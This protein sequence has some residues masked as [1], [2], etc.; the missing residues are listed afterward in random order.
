M[1]QPA[2]LYFA[3]GPGRNADVPAAIDR[4]VLDWRSGADPQ[5][6]GVLR[7]WGGPEQRAHISPMVWWAVAGLLAAL[8]AL[9]LQRQV[10]ERTRHLL[11]SE[12]KLA[13]ILDSVGAF[14]YI[15]GRDYRYQYANLHLRELFGRAANE[16]VG[17]DDAAFFESATATQIRA[18][19]RRVLELG[20]RIEV[21]ELNTHLADGAT[22]AY[23]S[24]KI[25]LRL[26]DGTIHALCGISTDITER[27]K[28]EESLRLAAS[29]FESFEGM[30][31]TGPDQRILKA[32]RSYARLTG[33][34]VDELL[35]QTPALLRSG[36]ATMRSSTK[37]CATA[38]APP[39]PGRAKCGTGARTARCTRLG[40][41]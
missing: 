15:K 33:Y 8:W 9:V 14:I 40:S 19:D 7:R 13:T 12:Q 22:R 31:V 24:V 17:Q 39:G 26:P 36:R 10:R 38:C 21:E 11:V 16:V 25:P 20:E 28:A 2:A 37:A 27:R 29:V 41:R 6:A 32:N 1:F 3:S 5:Y 34:T 23:L 35:G 30:V 18:N 4:S